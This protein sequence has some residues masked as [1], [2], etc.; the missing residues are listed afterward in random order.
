MVQHFTL[1]ASYS[2]ELI[3]IVV[4]VFLGNTDLILTELSN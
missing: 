4:F 3:G 2:Y 1:G